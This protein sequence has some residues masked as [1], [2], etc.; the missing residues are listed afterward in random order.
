MG[1]KRGNGEK[2]VNRNKKGI[3]MENKG[4]WGKIKGKR[5]NYSVKV[6]NEG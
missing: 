2:R 4:K 6:Q 1:K 5:G 3:K